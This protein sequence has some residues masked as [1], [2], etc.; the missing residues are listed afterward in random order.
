MMRTKLNLFQLF[1]QSISD[2]KQF[3]LLFVNHFLS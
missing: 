1:I 3:F 2:Y